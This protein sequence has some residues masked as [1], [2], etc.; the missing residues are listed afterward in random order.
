MKVASCSVAKKFQLGGCVCSCHITNFRLV[1]G[2]NQL[3][4]SELE[5]SSIWMRDSVVCRCLLNLLLHIKVFALITCFK[6]G[7]HLICS[8]NQQTPP[9]TTKPCGCNSQAVVKYGP[10]NYSPIVGRGGVV[11]AVSQIERCLSAL[12]HRAWLHV[13]CTHFCFIS[14]RVSDLSLRINLLCIVNKRRLF[15]FCWNNGPH[16]SSPVYSLFS[17]LRPRG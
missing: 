14:S 16:C 2:L 4:W 3:L 9:A 15:W 17:E 12:S 10:H 1:A 7:S 8:S 13:C 5:S 6:R 11:D